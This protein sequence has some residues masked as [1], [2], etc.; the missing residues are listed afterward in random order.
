[1]ASAGDSALAKATARKPKTRKGRKLL[2]Q[3][4]PQVV[5]EAKTALVIQGNKGS[6]QVTSLLRD[7]HRLRNPLSQLFTRTH[8]IHPF[9]DTGRLEALCNK[10]DHGLFAFGSSSK[11]RPFRLIMGR[12]FDAKLLDMIEFKV[13]DYK[14]I[15]SFAGCKKESVVGSKPLLVFQGAGFETDDRLKRT[16]SLLLDYFG[17]PRPDKVML[18]GLDHAIICTSSDPTAPADGGAA[19]EPVVTLRRFN[20]QYLKSGSKLPRVELQE[21]GPRFSLSVDRCKDP[22]RERWKQAIK[23]PK[24]AKPKKE[25]NIKTEALGKKRGR[26]HLGKQDFDQIHTV[27]HGKAKAKKLRADLDE[28]ARKAS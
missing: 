5:E 21:A 2:L 22:D 17:G 28:K 18:E 24:A 10:H 27:H 15:S 20:V 8:D 4:Q 23:V 12:L 7:L 6:A 3:R 1:M 26:I 14:S 19:P 25:K 11:K 13:D 16:K 9:E